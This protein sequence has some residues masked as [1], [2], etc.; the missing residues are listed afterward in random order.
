MKGNILVVVS[1]ISL[2]T[3]EA[4]LAKTFVFAFHIHVLYLVFVVSGF[5]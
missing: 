5:F 2:V 1:L 3:N 4:G